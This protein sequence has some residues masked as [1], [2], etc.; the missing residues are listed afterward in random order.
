MPKFYVAY[1]EDKTYHLVWSFRKLTETDI[2]SKC[3]KLIKL[4]FYMYL[5]WQLDDLFTYG[6]FSDKCYMK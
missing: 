5:W 3:T 2:C 4:S 1:Y 6:K